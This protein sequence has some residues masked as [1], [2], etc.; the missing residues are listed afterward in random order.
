[1]STYSNRLA[2]VALLLGA[3]LGTAVNVPVVL[4]QPSVDGGGAPA[5]GLSPFCLDAANQDVCLARD[6]ANVLGL[7]R[8][9]NAQQFAIYNT[10]TS[11]TNLE[12]LGIGWSGNN[13][14]VAIQKGSAGGTSQALVLAGGSSIRLRVG[15]ST[16]PA[17][18]GASDAVVFNGSTATFIQG[19]V[20]PSFNTT[21]NCSSAAS[22]AV[23]AAAAAGSVVIAGAATSVVVNTTAVTANSQVFAMIDRSLG[24]RLSV[25]CDTTS[26]LTTG[27]PAIT[28][29]TAG[30]SFT[31]AVP[32]A[33]AA[34]PM[35]LSYF[36]VN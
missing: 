16:Y 29:R 20:S 28:A 7:R 19:I 33:P 15:P 31:V 3:L 1:M 4:S 2:L 13:A 26:D 14:Y 30:T 10:F 12:S 36:I 22:P 23:C 24:T 6:A 17:L 9:T 5:F 34:N 35:C 32:V 8:G 27:S 11:L 18:D 25:T 21:A